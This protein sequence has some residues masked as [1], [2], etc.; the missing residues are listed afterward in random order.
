MESFEI[1]R[2]QAA[3]LRLGKSRSGL[4]K[5]VKQGT[6]VRPFK[7]GTRTAA[8]LKTETDALIQDRVAGRSVKELCKLVASLH[9]ARKTS[10]G[11]ISG[12][13]L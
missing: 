5:D 2:V 8:F 9:E 10:I 6:C 1:E 7:L 4:Y 3:C 11:R 12:V 13:T